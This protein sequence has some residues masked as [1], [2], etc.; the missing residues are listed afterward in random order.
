M[1]TSIVA[2][3]ST[4]HGGQR[5]WQDKLI[6]SAALAGADFVKFQSYQVKRLARSDRQYNWLKQAELSDA[7]HTRLIN[8]C[9]RAGVIFLTTVFHEDRVPFLADLGLHTIKVGSGEAM[10]PQLLEAIAHYPWRV[11]LS[12][13]L[14]TVAELDLAMEILQD[15][16]VVPLHTVSQYPTPLTEAN[17]GRIAWLAQYTGRPSGY[18]D[19][20]C[21]AD[22]PIYAV[23]QRVSVVE[24]HHSLPAAPR[25]LS[26]DK[27]F[28]QLRRICQFRDS[29][30]GMT[31]VHPMVRPPGE[32]RQY[33][34]RW[35]A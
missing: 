9:S 21:G 23:S 28:Q 25:F 11:F 7:D 34:G 3:L 13:G 12:T 15:H 8:A 1:G 10:R 20:T 27:N 33:V 26:W 18:S 17:M 31:L 32:E 4:S 6:E 2:E 5:A 35:T 30:S 16:Q 19:H 29:A 24:V 22:A 14:M